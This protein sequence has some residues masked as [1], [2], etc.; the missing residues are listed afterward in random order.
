MVPKIEDLFPFSGVRWSADG[1]SLLVRGVDQDGRGGIWQIYAQ[2][3][4]ASLLLEGIGSPFF[5][6]T[7]DGKSLVYSQ[8]IPKGLQF[9]VRDL[10]SGQVH[11]RE[12]THHQSASGVGLSPDGREVAFDTQAEHGEVPA[13]VVVPLA[14]GE[15]RAL[16]SLKAPAEFAPNTPAWTD[17]GSHFVFGV[18]P[19]GLALN[20]Q[21]TE[22]WEIP[23]E[24]GAPQKLDLTGETVRQLQIHPDGKRVAYV[25]GANSYEVGVMEN[26]LPSLRA[27]K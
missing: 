12:L 26:F 19:G 6:M 15:P 2:T 13:L 7:H 5:C 9:M 3:A 27:E 17:D 18:V 10:V 4:E 24:G 22:L 1:R 8:W 20:G 21:K 25:A 16:Y 14:G 11:V 23:A